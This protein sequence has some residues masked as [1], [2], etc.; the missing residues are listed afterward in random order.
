MTILFV[1]GAKVFLAAIIFFNLDL[2]S[3]LQQPFFS[4]QAFAEILPS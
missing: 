4:V 3:A 1:T 2:N